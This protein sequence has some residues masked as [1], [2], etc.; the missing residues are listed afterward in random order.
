M[1]QEHVFEGLD[2][3]AAAACTAAEFAGDLFGITCRAVN[4]DDVRWW[5]IVLEGD[6]VGV[7][8]VWSADGCVLIGKDVADVLASLCG[9]IV[10]D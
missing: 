8:Y 7:G 3:H 1:L 4:G 2:S 9:G 5:S 10:G 6:A